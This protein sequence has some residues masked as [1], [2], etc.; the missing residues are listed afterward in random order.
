MMA[1]PDPERTGSLYSMQTKIA[2]C[3]DLTGSSSDATTS[4]VPVFQPRRTS[5]SCEVTNRFGSVRTIAQFAAERQEPE[6]NNDPMPRRAWDAPLVG[7][8]AE[9]ATLDEAMRAAADGTAAVVLIAGEAG[10]GKSRLTA[11]AANRARADGWQVL[12]AGCL[13]LAEGSVPYLPLMDALHDL[14]ID[15]LSPLLTR[16][17]SGVAEELL[18]RGRSPP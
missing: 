10:I 11:E 12:S 5:R 14:P 8:A 16:W 6:R 3:D 15:T 9:L 18:R 13:D 1:V 7:R 17:L 4:P 2:H